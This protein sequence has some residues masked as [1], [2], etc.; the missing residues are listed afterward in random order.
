MKYRA[1]E[2]VETGGGNWLTQPGTYHVVI[3]GA[4]EEPHNAKGEL[5]DAFRITAQALEGTVK[6]ED[7]MFTEKDKTVDL[8]FFNPKLT[9]KN[10]GLFARQKQAR[11]FLAT[12]LLT[13]EQLGTEVDIDLEN[14]VGRQ[15]VLT[16]EEQ[17]G[18]GDRKF[19]SLHFADIW[20][21]DDPAVAKFPQ[22]VASKKLIPAPHR[23]DPK[24]FEKTNGTSPPKTKPTGKAKDVDLD[25]L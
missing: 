4:D 6:D 20:H 19:L 11:F 23:R 3:T 9:D 21:I 1:P 22:C 18:K 14:A 5:M 7:G 17:D 10:E 8:M 24:S 13:E 25:D 2:T 15:V 16:L 12:G